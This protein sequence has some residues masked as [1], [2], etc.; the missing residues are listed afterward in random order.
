MLFIV[1]RDLITTPHF[2]LSATHESYCNISLRKRERRLTEEEANKGRAAEEGQ[3]WDT[4]VIIL[5]VHCLFNDCTNIGPKFTHT[6]TAVF[7]LARTLVC[8]SADS[9]LASSDLY[10]MLLVNNGNSAAVICDLCCA[11][12]SNLLEQ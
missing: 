4:R 5:Q 11:A 9:Q 8:V 6:S 12:S 1:H 7:L 2:I 3:F 10:R